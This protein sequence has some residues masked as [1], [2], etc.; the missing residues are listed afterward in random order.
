MESDVPWLSPVCTLPPE[1]SW[2]LLVALFSRGDISRA[3]LSRGCGG[4]E[5]GAPGG[6]FCGEF[7]LLRF[8]CRGGWGGG[9]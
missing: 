8:R 5:Q 4:M 7:R 1:D 6:G 3:V 2:P 9:D